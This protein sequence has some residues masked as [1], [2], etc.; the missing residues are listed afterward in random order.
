[1]S[2]SSR[3]LGRKSALRVFLSLPGPLVPG[4]VFLLTL[5]L[6]NPVSV[7]GAVG[8]FGCSWVIL[9]M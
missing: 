8:K 2:D 7:R 9:V 1:M 5:L 3:L 6:G 4:E